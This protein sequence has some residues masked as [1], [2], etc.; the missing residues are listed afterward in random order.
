MKKS[1]ASNALNFD[2]P[3]GTSAMA[4]SQRTNGFV[5]HEIVTIAEDAKD[6]IKLAQEKG[7]GARCGALEL[8]KL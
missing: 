6:A 2:S 3:A 4:Q 7:C 1:L 5:R 8:E